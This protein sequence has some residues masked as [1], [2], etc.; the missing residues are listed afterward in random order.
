MLATITT[1]DKRTAHPYPGASRG[2]DGGW[3]Y[4]LDPYD[5]QV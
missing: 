1:S 3:E 5:M 4:I 2:C